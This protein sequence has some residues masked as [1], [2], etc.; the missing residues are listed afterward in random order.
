MPLQMSPALMQEN[1]KLGEIKIAVI[2]LGQIGLRFAVHLA[3]KGASVIGADIDK[4]KVN[5]IKQGICP[6]AE[7]PLVDT[8]QQIR[9]NGN[10]QV[11]SDST[12]AVKSSHIHIICAPTTLND[13]KTPDLNSLVAA[14]EAVGRG[15]KKGNLVIVESSVYPG[16]TTK[17]VKPTLEQV[18][19]LK[20]GEDFGLAYCFER[21]DPGNT[22]HRFD[23]TPKIISALDEA[24][25]NA[26][27]AVYKMIIDAPI[28]KVKNCETAELVKLVEN[29]YRDINI[30]FVNEIAVL[31]ER[32]GIDVLEVL[33]AASSKW[34]FTPHI[35]G[36]GVGGTCIPVNP[37][38]L[39]ECARGV[40][41]DLKLVRQAREIN[42][43]M[44]YHM[45]DLVKEALHKIGKPVEESKICI[46]GL[47]YKAD[48]DDTRGAP[49][50]TIGSGLE[51]L[52]A[53][54]VYYDP[55][56][57][58]QDHTPNIVSSLEE[59]VRDTDCVVITSEHSSFQSLDLQSI[60]NFAHNPL[61]IVDGRH[62]LLPREV[63][64]SGITYI[65]LGRDS[66]SDLNIWNSGLKDNSAKGT[67]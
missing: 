54:V 17:I 3:S 36:A 12:E 61:A 59:A 62:V 20:A 55:L 34:S 56:V 2:G 32:L 16:V 64:A 26:A 42:E 11:T 47:A 13:N 9:S 49:A 48:V 35:P 44:P 40:G 6:L 51:K 10:F 21:I 1:I 33:N 53:R 28:I 14:T 67:D 46:L 37:Y 24:S 5:S 43:G 50:E 58:R 57:I 25:M 4:R 29:V 27:V 15:L 52:G 8:F 39:L 7:N 18:S 19:G 60:S 66:D 23:N 65:G 45:I 30:A 38:Y 22:E 41:L 63:K 31:C